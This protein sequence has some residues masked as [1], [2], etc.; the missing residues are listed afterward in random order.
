M[1]SVSFNY[2][3][4]ERQV[5]EIDNNVYGIN[6]L[7][8]IASGEIIGY[9]SYVYTS[10][11]AWSNEGPKFT[12]VL[13][14]YIILNE[15]QNGNSDQ[16]N[17]LDLQVLLLSYKPEQLQDGYTYNSS[18]YSTTTDVSNNSSVKIYV[19]QDGSRTYELNW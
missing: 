3:K 12:T 4:S 18:L 6:P 15:L 1:P 5:T 8:D 10:Q 17:T 7:H 16:L 13:Y 19:S 11:P 9:T 14:Q 2:L